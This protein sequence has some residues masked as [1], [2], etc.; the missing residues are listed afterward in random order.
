MSQS[1]D[2]VALLRAV[3]A[4]DALSAGAMGL[5]LLFVP[6]AMP[7]LLGLPLWLTS[8]AGLALL[9]FA[10]FAAWAATR[11]V[12]PRPAVWTIIGLNAAWAAESLATVA[13][14]LVSATALGAAFV[15]AQA[16]AVGLFAVLQAML[17][18]RTPRLA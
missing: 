2:P 17:L 13:G 15:V 4:A 12:P 18:V 3:L 8:A 9:P 1:R 16:V 7:A 10:A 11:R 5:L 14:G 6:A